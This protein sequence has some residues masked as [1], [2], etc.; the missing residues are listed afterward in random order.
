MNRK[1]RKKID[2]NKIDFMKPI[3]F[4]KIGSKDDPCFGKY[5]DAKADECRRCGD[6]ELCVVKQ[7]Q[8]V[9]AKRLEEADRKIYRD[10]TT[11]VPR[12]KDPVTAIPP[13]IKDYFS[14][15]LKLKSINQRILKKFP[16][17]DL[18]RI[19]RIYKKLKN[20]KTHKH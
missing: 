8:R 1:P 18:E 14:K 7:S 9:A 11:L 10:S 4:S 12:D 3:D 13:L 19:K 2:L 6:S 20:E 16:G 15:G 5:H 17:T